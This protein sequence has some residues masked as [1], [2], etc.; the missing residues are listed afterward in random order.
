MCNVFLALKWVISVILKF[1]FAN[2]F[3]GGVG[4]HM[5]IFEHL[6][7]SLRVILSSRHFF[8]LSSPPTNP[9]FAV[10]YLHVLY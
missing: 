2:I 7:H 10:M 9:S 8:P 1:M 3:G 4:D 6:V 5:G